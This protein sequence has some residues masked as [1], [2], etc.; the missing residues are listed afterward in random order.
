MGEYWEQ[1][2]TKI[3]K[4]P[5]SLEKQK[6]LAYV[7]KLTDRFPCLSWYVRQKPAEVRPMSD[8]TT[9]EV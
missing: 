4:W 6:R 5:D 7:D 1:L 8:H 3:N 9:G 2:K